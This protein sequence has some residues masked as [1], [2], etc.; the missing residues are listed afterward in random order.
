MVITA[1]S[2]PFITAGFGP[3]AMKVVGNKNG[4]I[5]YHDRFVLPAGD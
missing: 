5:V 1:G 3:S 4:Q 2:R